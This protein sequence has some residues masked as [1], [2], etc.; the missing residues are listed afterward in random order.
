M[1]TT[2]TRA[3]DADRQADTSSAI[4]GEASAATGPPSQQEIALAEWALLNESAMPTVALDG[5]VQAAADRATSELDDDPDPDLLVC[6][7]ITDQLLIQLGVAGGD[8]AAA[9]LHGPLISTLYALA[10]SLPTTA[11][12]SVAGERLLAGTELRGGLTALLREAIGYSR[13]GPP[14]DSEAAQ[15]AQAAVSW[16]NSELGITN[17]LVRAALAVS[18]PDSTLQDEPAS[19]PD[20]DEADV[21][22]AEQALEADKTNQ[23]PMMPRT[24]MSRTGQP[25]RRQSKRPSRR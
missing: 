21:Q 7:A 12:R 22:D 23:T 17:E 16:L 15:L 11:V 13:A 4:L 25:A 24:L 2:G 14:D 6:A 20:E 10:L 1:T 18:V 3:L 8:E 9:E 5:G 19:D